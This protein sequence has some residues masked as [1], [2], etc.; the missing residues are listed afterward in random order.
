MTISYRSG[1]PDD[2]ECIARLYAQSFSDTFA[3]LY[4]PA[5]LAA[6]LDTRK[7]SDFR[8][9]LE[10]GDF[11]FCLAEDRGTLAGFIKLGPADL[12]VDT[13]AGTIEL[14]QLYVLEPWHGA[15]VA[16]SLMERGLQAARSAGVCHIQLNVYIDNHRAQRFY[17]RYGFIPVDRCTFMVGDHADEE[18]VMRLRL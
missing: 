2:A 1:T 15:G 18:V 6:F 10:S 5:D 9:E 4:R 14:R 16:A 12:P 11:H 17:S 7:A 13:P 8:P 3:H